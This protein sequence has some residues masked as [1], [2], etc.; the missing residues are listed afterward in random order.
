MG[1]LKKARSWDTSLR[2]AYVEYRVFAVRGVRPADRADH[3]ERL[4]LN[5]NGIRREMATRSA[6][7]ANIEDYEPYTSGP[8]GVLVS[9]GRR[10]AGLVTA[11]VAA[12]SRSLLHHRRYGRR[13]RPHVFGEV[14]RV[15]LRRLLALACSV[16]PAPDRQS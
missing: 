11:A 9:P 8:D 4:T 12:G 1:E 16:N 14:G 2:L 13:R 3:E 6:R 10:R 15:G 7:I 5:R